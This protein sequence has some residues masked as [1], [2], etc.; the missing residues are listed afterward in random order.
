MSEQ[1]PQEQIPQHFER[2]TPPN[3]ETRRFLSMVTNDYQKDYELKLQPQPIISERTLKT[4]WD[5]SNKDYLQY[6]VDSNTNDDWMREY[7]SGITRD[8]V[9]AFISAL[10]KRMIQAQITAQ[11][12]NQIVDRILSRVTQTLVNFAVKND[13]R[14]FD[15]GHSKFVRAVHKSTI[16][17]TMHKLIFINADKEHET[18]IIPNEEVYIPNFFQFDLQKQGHF[19]YVQDN[20]TY[21]EA[22]AEFGEFENFKYVQPGNVYIIGA[23]GAFTK[24]D[25]RHTSS[26]VQEKK[27]QVIRAWYPVPKD[28]LKRGQKRAKYF[29]IIVNG[30]PMLD[31]DNIDVYNHGYYPITKTVFEL[32]DSHYYWGNSLPNKI[33]HDKKWITALKTI[34]ANLG[35]LNMLPPMFAEDGLNIDQEVYVPAK[36]TPIT[37][38]AEQLKAVPGLHPITQGDV[39]L[40]AMAEKSGDEGS[41]SPTGQGQEG[42]SGRTL[43]EIQLQEAN[44]AEL[45]QLF[46]LMVAFGVEQDTWLL[47][48]NIY[49]F[50]PRKKINELAKI[51]V[52]NQ[53]LASGKTGTMEIIFEDVLKLSEQERAQKERASVMEVMRSA[54][55]GIHKEVNY[56]DPSYARNAQWFLEVNGNPVN[57]KSEEMERYLAVATYRELHAGNPNISQE[58]ATRIAVRATTPDEEDNLVISQ[59]APEM[60][61]M[62]ATRGNMEGMPG[63]EAPMTRLPNKLSGALALA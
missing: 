63:A 1:L 14:P 58:E 12:K 62:T 36:I 48:H 20:I 2:Y 22:K 38:K 15:N 5:Q 60:P 6:Q 21:E 4:F 3:E 27:C 45:K 16:E 43:G 10:V 49:Q 56:I 32:L 7:P 29:N 51:S 41:V 52:P 26:I 25:G 11:N 23:N 8:K 18:V 13:G 28:K 17:G 40:L 44:A 54:R 42:R 35:K 46:G 59:E 57:R 30:I 61:V 34:L 31:Y 55:K 19:L 47:I 9:N 33:R 53:K 39:A 37:G 50:F 24:E